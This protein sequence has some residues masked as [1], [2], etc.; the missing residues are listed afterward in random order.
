MRFI[1]FSSAFFIF[2]EG[3]VCTLKVLMVQNAGIVTL[4][5]LKVTIKVSKSNLIIFALNTL[6]F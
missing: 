6:E 3:Y 2:R 5:D 1:A 4:R